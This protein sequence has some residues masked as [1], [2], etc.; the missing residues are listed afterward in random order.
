MDAKE[1]LKIQNAKEKERDHF[2]KFYR[3][4]PGEESFF[5]KTTD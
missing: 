5:T 1:N 3:K 4:W 2:S